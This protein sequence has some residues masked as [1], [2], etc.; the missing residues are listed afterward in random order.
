VTDWWC[1]DATT[2]SRFRSPGWYNDSINAFQTLYVST[3]SGASLD[4]VRERRAVVL[5]GGWRPEE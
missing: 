1:V 4:A 5:E 2:L 3:R